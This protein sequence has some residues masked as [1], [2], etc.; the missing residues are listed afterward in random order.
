MNPTGVSSIAT[1][2]S[3]PR[4]SGDEPVYL[5]GVDAIGG[6]SPRERG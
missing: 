2:A 1:E 6:Y 5:N 4:V 3:I